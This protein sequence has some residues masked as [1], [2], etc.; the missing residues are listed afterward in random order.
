MDREVTIRLT[1]AGADVTCGD[2][3]ESLFGAPSVPKAKSDRYTVMVDGEEVFKSKHILGDR[4]TELL[5][6]HKVCPTRIM[7]YDK[8]TQAVFPLRGS[9]SCCKGKER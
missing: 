3:Q 7:F 4:V 9:C 8:V 6:R 2:K 1:D 5:F